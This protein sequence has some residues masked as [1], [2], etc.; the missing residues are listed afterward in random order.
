MNNLPQIFYCPV[1]NCVYN[2]HG[3]ILEIKERD[4]KRWV[5]YKDKQVNVKSLEQKMMIRDFDDFTFAYWSKLCQS[6]P[7]IAMG[8]YVYL[9]MSR[10]SISMKDYF[11]MEQE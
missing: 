5:N 9:K 2:T 6:H 3:K 10:K 11:K 1:R 7:C 4:G 8:Y